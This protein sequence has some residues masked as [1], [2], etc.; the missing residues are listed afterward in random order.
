MATFRAAFYKGTQA[1]MPGIYN[2]IVRWWTRSKYSHVELVF[3]DGLAAS[4]S[5]PD[6]GVRFRRIQFDPDRWDVVDLPAHLAPAAL[7]WFGAHAGQPYDWLGVLH[8]ALSP[9]GDNNQRWFCSEAAAAALGMP[10]PARFDPG[11][12]HAAL[13]FINQPASA[14][15]SFSAPTK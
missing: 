14:G 11:T 9:V 8:F 15:F 3:A 6:G 7:A 2:R 1:G 10:D 4:A 12:L 5:A 13:S